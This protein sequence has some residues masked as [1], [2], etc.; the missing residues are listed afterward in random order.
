[1]DSEIPNMIATSF[2]VS[3]F[4]H[5]LTQLSQSLNLMISTQSIDYVTDV[6]KSRWNVTGVNHE[7]RYK[8]R[9]R[10]THITHH[11]VPSIEQ[12]QRLMC[13]LGRIWRNNPQIPI[14]SYRS[15]RSVGQIEVFACGCWPTSRMIYPNASKEVTAA[16]SIEI[17]RVSWGMENRPSKNVSMMSEAS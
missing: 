13:W 8:D 12:T 5:W 16:A 7:T 4:G 1:M 10:D 15:A 3:G 17:N 6:K 2:V 9:Q 14:G 11:T